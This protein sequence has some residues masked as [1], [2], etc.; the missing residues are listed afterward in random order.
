MPFYDF[1]CAK[2][3]HEY[4]LLLPVDKTG[5]HSKA[6]CPECGS[7]KKETIINSCGGYAFAQPVGTDRWVS[8]AGGHGY[9]F[10]Y[11]KPNVRKQ[12]AFAEA[13]SHMGATPYQDTTAQDIELD[14]GIHDAESRKGLS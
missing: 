7:K 11:N 5:K 10:E 14:V 2:C 9:R 13:M 1:R 4:E 6:V 12:R 8:E 3:N